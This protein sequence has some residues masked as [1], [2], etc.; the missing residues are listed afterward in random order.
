MELNALVCTDNYNTEDTLFLITKNTVGEECLYEIPGFLGEPSIVNV[1][2]ALGDIV[3]K[4]SSGL[5]DDSITE[6][7]L[8]CIKATAIDKACLQLEP[9]LPGDYGPQVLSAIRRRVLL[10]QGIDLERYPALEIE[11]V[12]SPLL[13]LSENVREFVTRGESWKG[14]GHV[15]PVVRTKD[16]YFAPSYHSQN[17]ANATENETFFVTTEEG[18]ILGLSIDDAIDLGGSIDLVSGETSKQKLNSLIGF[19]LEAAKGL[20]LKLTDEALTRFSAGIKE[21]KK[22][23]LSLYQAF[24]E[25]QVWDESDRVGA[26]WQYSALGP[27][28]SDGG[29]EEAKRTR[30]KAFRSLVAI[31]CRKPPRQHLI[32]VRP[33]TRPTRQRSPRSARRSASVSVRG[34]DS[35]DDDSGESDPPAP[36]LSRYGC[37]Y[38]SVTCNPQ[39]I[40]IVSVDLISRVPM[41][42]GHFAW[43][44]GGV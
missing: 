25:G 35:G 26:P 12:A 40:T 36:P 1:A 42:D 13:S 5:E 41:A 24:L 11:G 2:K 32:T 31:G 16:G 7:F 23:L 18:V 3:E 10:S 38:L 28:T 4:V 15:F 17:G 30:V 43:T 8:A 21:N 19:F 29:I 14:E 39:P 44:F 20:G 22:E 6:S 34:G 33:S 27:Y 9:F 37:P